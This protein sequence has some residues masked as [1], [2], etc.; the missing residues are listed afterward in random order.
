[1]YI[2]ELKIHAFR[3]LHDAMFGPFRQPIN[4]SELIILAGPNGGGKSSVLELLSEG[5]TSR[6]GWQLWKPRGVQ[7]ESFALKIGFDQAEIDE[8]SALDL[9]DRTPNEEVREPERTQRMATATAEN[10]RLAVHLDKHKGYWI[11]RNL[12]VVDAAEAEL[13]NRVITLS[14]RTYSA[15][16]RKIG[17]FIRSE[18][19]YQPRGYNYGNMLNRARRFVA[20]HFNTFSYSSTDNQYA[21]I[22][23]F[24]IEQSYDYTRQLGEYQ[25]ALMRQEAAT[26]PTDPIKPYNELLGR[27][28]PGYSFVDVDEQHLSLRIKLPTGNVIEF[29][30]LSSGEKEV[31]FILALFVRHGINKS[32]IVIDEPDLHLHPELA[33]KMVRALRTI[34]P[35]N[36]IWCATH[37]AELIDEAGRERTFF[38][39]AS[40]DRTRS[41]CIPATAENAELN[42][43]RDMYGYSGYVGISKKVVFSEGNSSSADR[44]TFTNLFP[45]KADE[46]KIIP[47]GGYRE[48]FRV[49]SAVLALLESDFARCE[50]YLIRDHDYLSEAAIAKHTSH[51]PGRLFVLRRYHIENYLIDEDVISTILHSIYQKTLSAL[52]VREQLLRIAKAISGSVL[53]DLAVSRLNELYQSEDCSIAKHS[54]TLAVTDA[55]GVRDDGVIIPL[56]TALLARV[57]GVNGDISLRTTP[58]STEQIVDDATSAVIDA[59][60]SDGWKTLFPGRRLLQKFSSEN[61]LGDWPVLQNLIIEKMS[62]TP[63]SI[64]EELKQIFDTIAP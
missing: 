7:N 10:A 17:F 41:E 32:I 55:T 43:L 38:L 56:R 27:I 13:N 12:N 47:A 11:E 64:P 44:K 51:A 26:L 46:I 48:L 34:Q 30:E 33:R 37:S 14:Q 1:M 49:N 16:T 6:Y 39:R 45:G 50:F 31:F 61:G 21:E 5:L 58:A 8:I 18:R 57:A 4:P 36:Q 20:N 54:E 25:K 23:E 63:S 28:F 40:E 60:S 15:F 52:Q 59:L 2:V 19:S 9:R 22:H 62:K 42:I 29:Q 24:L 35:E 53:R 3:H